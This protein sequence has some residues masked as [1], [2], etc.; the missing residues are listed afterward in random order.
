VARATRY[1]TARRRRGELA[2]GRLVVFPDAG[3]G[4]AMR[5]ARQAVGDLVNAC[6]RLGF[7][8]VAGA[9]VAILA[10]I[11]LALG[12]WY[13]E[14][15]ASPRKPR[16]AS[17]SADATSVRRTSL[18]GL[19]YSG[20]VRAG[21][22]ED[23]ER[24]ARVLQGFDGV[25][26]ASVFLKPGQ[27]L[28]FEDEPEPPT[29]VALVTPAAGS[30]I[31][32]Q[33]IEALGQCLAAAA[34]GAPSARITVLAPQGQLLYRDGEVLCD[35]LRGPPL[36]ADSAPAPPASSPSRSSLLLAL[37]AGALVGGLLAFLVVVAV[38]SAASRARSRQEGAPPGTVPEPF[39]FLQRVT[40]R[41]AAD[42]LREERPAVQAVALAALD[43]PRRRRVLRDLESLGLPAPAA[44]ASAAEPGVTPAAR[45]AVESALREKWLRLAYRASASGGG[46]R[47]VGEE[48]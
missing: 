3:G 40:P 23:E 19:P 18:T 28:L 46:R 47:E 24:L 36:V 7:W 32:R 1:V 35:S 11:A 9:A 5:P 25:A 12:S 14:P 15:W 30:R 29:V 10:V 37:A 38:P 42:L 17:P 48:R 13:G 44:D 31:E 6:G 39:E 34:P 8:R 33:E 41:M 45:A 20:A 22:Q 43:A 16:A 27:K 26:E 2:S 4:F 21:V